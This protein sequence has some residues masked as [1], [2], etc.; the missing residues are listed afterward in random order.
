MPMVGAL[1]LMALLV[2]AAPSTAGN[3]DND[4]STDKVRQRKE[5]IRYQG[6]RKARHIAAKQDG[7]NNRDDRDM[8]RQGMDD[9]D[10]DG[11]DRMR[12]DDRTQPVARIIPGQPVRESDVQAVIAN[13]PM[14]PKDQANEMM[15]K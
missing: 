10:M 1:A 9:R 4:F 12:D 6:S 14:K 15:A 2:G 8:D 7:M 3:A 5:T 11:P 13:W